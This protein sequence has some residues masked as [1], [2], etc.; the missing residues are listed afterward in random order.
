MPMPPPHAFTRPAGRIGARVRPPGVVRG[1]GDHAVSHEKVTAN[2][3]EFTADV[4][5]ISLF[6]GSYSTALFE[7]IGR[8]EDLPPVGIAV[9][10][11]EAPSLKR[12]SPT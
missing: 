8:G 1:P 11:V 6:K 4:D 7:T 3:N 12:R 5:R 10:D 9:I 2:P